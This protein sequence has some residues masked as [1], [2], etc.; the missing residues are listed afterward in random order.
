MKLIRQGEC[1]RCGECCGANGK[2]AAW[3]GWY[4][5]GLLRWE[6]EDLKQRWPHYEILGITEAEDGRMILTTNSGTI[7]IRGDRYPWVWDDNGLHKPGNN[8][9]P[10]LKDDDGEG[11]LDCGAVGTQYEQ[12]VFTDFCQNGRTNHGYPSHVYEDDDPELVDN[13]RS[14][15]DKKADF[16][17]EFPSCSFTYIEE[18]E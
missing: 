4:V 12:K 3:P 2:A 6:V 1:N 17:D 9:C 7:R 8:E 10:I 5:N 14:A 11:H 15:Y 18:A 13:P 16:Y